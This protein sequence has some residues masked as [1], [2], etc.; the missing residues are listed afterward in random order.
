[1][2]K[3]K[4]KDAPICGKCRELGSVRQLIADVKAI[5]EE[6]NTSESHVWMAYMIQ[7][8]RAMRRGQTIHSMA[9]F[10]GSI[11]GNSRFNL[12]NLMEEE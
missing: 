7:E 4:P 6:T 2:G 10:A 11:L 8:V 9:S 3:K 12:I 5:S 1:M